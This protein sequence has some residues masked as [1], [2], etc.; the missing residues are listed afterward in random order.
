MRVLGV[1]AEYNPFHNGHKYHIETAK[2]AL[3]ADGVIAVMSGN[4]VQRGEP[5]LFDKFTRAKYALLGGVDLVIELPAYFSLK[6]A[7]GFARGGIEL[8]EATGIVDAVSFGSECGD[9]KK[10]RQAAR[11]LANEPEGFKKTLAQ[12]LQNGASFASARESAIK[13]INPELAAVVRHPNNILAVEYLKALSGSGIKPHTV[14]RKG[15]YHSKSADVEFASATALREAIM[16]GEDVYRHLPY[17]PDNTGRCSFPDFEELILYSL[18]VSKTQP[19]DSGD[20]LWERIQKGDKN[21][22]DALLQST[23]T[24]RHTMARIKRALIN[25]VIDNHLPE[26]L[27]PS[28]IR[29]LGIGRQG[30]KLLNVM[31]DK[32]RLPVIIKPSKYRVNDSIWHLESRATDIYSLITGRKQGENMTI[33]PVIIQ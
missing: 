25:Q 8:L 10:L 6:S 13:E 33:S 11:I 16:S 4:Y 7:E 1:V 28:Y 2:T 18:T 15:E 32:A 22:L 20:G 30:A 12:K 24:R 17:M 5:A 23:K 14:K 26:N 27:P 21:S 3:S 31:K 29:V 19:P 9:I